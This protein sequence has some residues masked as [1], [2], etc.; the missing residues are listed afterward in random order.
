MCGTTA[1]QVEEGAGEVDL[2]HPAPDVGIELP[3]R[4][5]AAGDP[6]V[7]DQDVDA[8][9]AGECRLRRGLDRRP[10]RSARRGPR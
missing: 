7:V 9:R 8:A 2:E 6:G 4:S 1:R 5:V 3:R 10:R